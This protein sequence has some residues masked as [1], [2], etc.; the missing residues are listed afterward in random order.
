VRCLVS[1][2]SGF[3]GSH[4]VRQLVDAG[5]EVHAI[6]GPGS[7]GPPSEAMRIEA[8]LRSGWPM[9]TKYDS[10][11]H[12]AGLSSV[13]ESFGEPVKYIESASRMAV[14]LGESALR[15][16][17]NPRVVLVSSGSIY[18]GHTSRPISENDSLAFTSP[19]AVSKH[20]AEAVA[21][22]YM[23]RGLDWI[24]VRPFNHVGPGQ[25][26]GFI[27]SDLFRSLISASERGSR[28]ILTGDLTTRRDYT[29]VRDVCR[30]YIALAEE[31]MLPFSTFNVCS[32]V[33][34][35]GLEIWDEI[36][37]ALGYGSDLELVPDSS[38]F[39]PSDPK[40]MVGDPARIQECVG[41]SP[42]ISVA[43]SIR[44]FVEQSVR[45]GLR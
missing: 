45:D 26:A 12:L 15:Q 40:V 30:A 43:E 24:V 10:I 33:T 39:R 29:D 7:G 41:W 31:S 11:F 37:G 21:H 23:N 28:S 3:V 9:L 13:G 38:R 19:Y 17:V 42:R 18:D 16:G 8:D 5:H 22:Y 25:R 6:V 36:V 44:S 34:V 27:V 1:G 32:G 14:E 2:A 20:A 4:L 35:S